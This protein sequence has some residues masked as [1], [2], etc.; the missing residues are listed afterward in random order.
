[1]QSRS[2]IS[3]PTATRLIAVEPDV[4]PGEVVELHWMRDPDASMSTAHG[5][6][7][8][9]LCG[10]WMEADEPLAASVACGSLP[11]RYISCRA[12]DLLSHLI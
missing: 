11:V 3:G 1:M 10:A 12:C 5:L 6:S 2:S 4:T 7:V 9:A 8:P